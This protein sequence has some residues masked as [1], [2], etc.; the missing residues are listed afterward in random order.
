MPAYLFPVCE[1][2][3][4]YRSV[5]RARGADRFEPPLPLE[6]TR[7]FPQGWIRVAPSPLAGERIAGE[8]NPNLAWL[9]PYHAA[10]AG[11]KPGVWRRQSHG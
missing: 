7:G 4:L 10:L 5:C 9:A 11:L 1:T 2:D 8:P 3:G 6:S